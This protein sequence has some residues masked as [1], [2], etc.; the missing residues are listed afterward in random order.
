MRGTPLP[1]EKGARE[2]SVTAQS[3]TLRTL[4]PRCRLRTIGAPSRAHPRIPRIRLRPI[5]V[6]SCSFVVQKLLLITRR[7]PEPQKPYPHFG[8]PGL[9]AR[10]AGPLSGTAC[11]LFRKAGQDS[12]TSNPLSGQAGLP[13]RR[14]GLLLGKP[15]LLFKNDSLLLV[16]AGLKFG[17]A[18]LHISRASLLSS[19]ASLLFSISGLLFQKAGL[20]SGKT[21]PLFRKCGRRF[22]SENTPC[23]S[24]PP[25]NR[26]FAPLSTLPATGSALVPLSFYFRSAS[27]SES[28][29]PYGA[30]YHKH[31]EQASDPVSTPV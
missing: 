7:L 31:R 13:F 24:Q 19:R 23:P 12:C 27:Q 11:L 3:A 2:H 20:K 15:G 17:K 1:R 9:P 21:N 28:P 16:K 8:K 14:A 4:A 10:K 25:R 29:H 18:G 22:A 26:P 6:D 30:C 5:R